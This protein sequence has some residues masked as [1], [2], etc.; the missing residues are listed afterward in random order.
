MGGSVIRHSIWRLMH[1]KYSI[2]CMSDR[3]IKNVSNVATQW[4][5]GVFKWWVVHFFFSCSRIYLWFEIIISYISQNSTRQP[6]E[7]RCELVASN[8][9]MYTVCVGRGS[10]NN[11]DSKSQG[12]EFFHSRKKWVTL[13]LK[14]Q[15]ALWPCRWRNG[16]LCFFFGLSRYVLLLV[17]DGL[18]SDFWRIKTLSDI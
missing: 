7:N 6:P 18:T 13:L 2:T 8:W 15:R 3:D 4:I 10:N 12:A 14:T 5:P 11:R 16:H 17:G 9:V 1:I